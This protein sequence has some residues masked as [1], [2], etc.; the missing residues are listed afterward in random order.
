MKYE[1]GPL[2]VMVK[3]GLGR[4]WAGWLLNENLEILCLAN[5]IRPFIFRLPK[6]TE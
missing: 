4:G 1:S 3:V 6:L 2:A 5:C